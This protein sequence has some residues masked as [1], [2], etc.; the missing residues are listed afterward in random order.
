MPL[1]NRVVG[2][3]YY[4]VVGMEP[5]TLLKYKFLYRTYE[6]VWLYF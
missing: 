3:S 1:K 4:K 5:T 2:N 6:R